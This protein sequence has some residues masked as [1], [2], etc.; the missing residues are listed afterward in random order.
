MVPDF[1]LLTE[2]AGPDGFELEF[3]ATRIYHPAVCERSYGIAKE[4]RGVFE[5][6]P[7]VDF[8]TGALCRRSGR[9]TVYRTHLFCCCIR[10]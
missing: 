9:G 10:T 1:A 7:V 6:G 8:H 4:H 3:I 5:E 2:A